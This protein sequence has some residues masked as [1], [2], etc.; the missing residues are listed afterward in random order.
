[1]TLAE[2][3]V[4]YRTVAPSPDGRFLAATFTYDLAFRPLEA[5]LSS[6]GEQVHLLDA[7]GRPLA[8]LEGS[9]R[10]ADHSPDWSR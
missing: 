7:S 9:W 2:G 10:H 8:T 5:L 4:F 1:V 6:H 3:P